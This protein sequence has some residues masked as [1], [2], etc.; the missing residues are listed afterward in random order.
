MERGV[1][2]DMIQHLGNL[3][4]TMNQLPSDLRNLLTGK[5]DRLIHGYLHV[6][7]FAG[8]LTLFTFTESP[9]GLV[10]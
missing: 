8:F 10:L 3:L 9:V 6:P 7:K 5:P 4:I 2:L 1:R